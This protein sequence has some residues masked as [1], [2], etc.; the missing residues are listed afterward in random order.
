MNKIQTTWKAYYNAKFYS[1]EGLFRIFID[2]EK[3]NCNIFCSLKKKIETILT[4]IMLSKMCKLKDIESNIIYWDI[5][6][7]DSKEW[8]LVAYNILIET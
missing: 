7:R 4:E 6:I 1:K 5:I 8:S 2:E 3:I